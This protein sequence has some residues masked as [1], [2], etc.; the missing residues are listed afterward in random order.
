MHILLL[1]GLIQQELDRLPGLYQPEPTRGPC[2]DV[3]EQDTQAPAW[4]V[5]QVAL[6]HD[7][8]V[9]THSRWT[10]WARIWFIV[11]LF[12][13]LCMG[14]NKAVDPVHGSRLMSLADVS[15]TLAKAR[16]GMGSRAWQ[17]VT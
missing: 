17:G 9:H 4:A 6:G 12:T 5:L 13:C 3:S 8:A 16:P 14:C 15:A 10:R 7:I 2:H 1:E 11:Y